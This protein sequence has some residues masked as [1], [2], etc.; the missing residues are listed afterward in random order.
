MVEE[1]GCWRLGMTLEWI[2]EEFHNA[3]ERS[4]GIFKCD[5]SC[6]VWGQVNTVHDLL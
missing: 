1:I 5:R 6:D 4:L 3:L 2:E